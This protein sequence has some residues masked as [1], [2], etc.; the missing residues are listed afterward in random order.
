MCTLPC[1]S[2]LSLIL[3]A[4]ALTNYIINKHFMH[5]PIIVVLLSLSCEEEMRVCV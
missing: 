5:V 1:R 3:S 2:G 4:G